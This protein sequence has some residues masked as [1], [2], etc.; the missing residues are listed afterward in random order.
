MQEIFWPTANRSTMKLED[1]LTLNH[2]E[3]E[4]TEMLDFRRVQIEHQVN[5]FEVSQSIKSF[6]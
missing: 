2:I 6:I 4:K 1:G 5:D 3:E